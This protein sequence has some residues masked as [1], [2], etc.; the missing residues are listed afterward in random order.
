MIEASS[1]SQKRERIVSVFSIAVVELTD[2]LI[3]WDEVESGVYCPKMVQPNMVFR[4]WDSLHSLAW[5]LEA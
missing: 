2:D 4:H 5:T 1:I 3:V